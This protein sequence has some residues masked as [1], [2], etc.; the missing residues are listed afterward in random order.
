MSDN[1]KGP[2]SISMP[3]SEDAPGPPLNHC[4]TNIITDGAKLKLRTGAN[5]KMD[6]R[7]N[8]IT[9]YQDQRCCLRANFRL[10]KPIMHFQKPNGISIDESRILFGRHWFW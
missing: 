3:Y 5:K 10:N 7:N 9:A 1:K 2:S 8:R 4:N 6:E